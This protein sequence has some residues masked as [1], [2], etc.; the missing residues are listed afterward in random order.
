MVEAPVML[1]GLFGVWLDPKKNLLPCEKY[2]H[3]LLRVT[4]E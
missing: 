1:R 3:S 4:F 2:Q